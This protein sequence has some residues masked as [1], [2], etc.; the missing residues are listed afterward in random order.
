MRQAAGSAAAEVSMATQ[1]AG[2][3]NSMHR[4]WLNYR[5]ILPA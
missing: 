3:S 5:S 1:D 4:I 2:N